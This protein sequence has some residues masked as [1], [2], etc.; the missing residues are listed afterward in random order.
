VKISIEVLAT[1]PAAGA[2]LCFHRE[3]WRSLGRYAGE[4][5][6]ERNHMAI[7]EERSTGS[8]MT[9]TEVRTNGV[10]MAGQW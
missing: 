2:E 4:L 3:K 10:T 9:A 7:R 8:T 6:S 1:W 5:Y